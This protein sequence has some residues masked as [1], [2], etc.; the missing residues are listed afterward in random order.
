M[1]FS[2]LKPEEIT[3]KIQ[4]ALQSVQIA[5]KAAKEWKMV[6]QVTK[7]DPNGNLIPGIECEVQLQMFKVKNKEYYALLF[8]KA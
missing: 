1:L 2:F 6:Y 4:K 5:P 8:T 3:K 7:S